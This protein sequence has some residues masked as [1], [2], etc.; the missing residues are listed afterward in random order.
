MWIDDQIL[1]QFHKTLH[2]EIFV[3][4]T[5]CVVLGSGNDEALEVNLASCQ[6]ASISVMRRYGGGG[7]VVLY[8]GC[9]VVSLGCWVKEQF[10]NTLYFRL[11]NQAVI[12][13]LAAT[14]PNLNDLSQAGLSDIT[15]G[16]KKIAGTSLFRSRNYLLYQA[17]LLVDLDQELVSRVLRHPT[18]EPDYR[19]GRSHGE[20]LTSLMIAES[21]ISSATQVAKELKNNLHDCVRKL[22]G[23]HLIEPIIDQTPALLARLER[24]QG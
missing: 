20:F 17:S 2:V 24:S 16:D 11:I 5:T 22:L 1:K 15:L 7:T 13:S 18:K 21:K 14:W 6:E 9:V 3:P 8:P 19:H 4:Q 10:Q 23:D 12:N